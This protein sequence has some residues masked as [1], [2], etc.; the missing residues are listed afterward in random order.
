MGNHFHAVVEPAILNAC[1]FTALEGVGHYSNTE[2]K[3]STDKQM[4]SRTISFL[5]MAPMISLG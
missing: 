2:D 5:R 4:I 1:N 3:I